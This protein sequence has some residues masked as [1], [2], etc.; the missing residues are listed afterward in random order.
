MGILSS[1]G[2]WE[3][4]FLIKKKSHFTEQVTLNNSCKSLEHCDHLRV[5]SCKQITG[6]ALYHSSISGIF[7]F[8]F[9]YI[10]SMLKNN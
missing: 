8:I 3:G 5:D 1:T 10:N 4:I 9:F 6:K 7:N 2:F